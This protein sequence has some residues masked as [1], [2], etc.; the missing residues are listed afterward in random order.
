MLPSITSKSCRV[1]AKPFAPMFN[2]MA[3]VC[4]VR[5]GVKLGPMQRKAE[6]V[7]D[8]AKRD[9][10]RPLSY[11]AKQAQTAFNAYVRHRDRHLPCV[12]CGTTDAVQWQAGHYLSVGAR[13]ELRFVETQVWRQCSQCN[14]YLSGNLIP[15]RAELIRRIGLAEV[16]RLEG[17]HEPRRYRADDYRAIR[18]DYR[19]RLK[20]SIHRLKGKP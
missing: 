5:C 19:A 1:C 18:D 9:K 12:S 8:K 13:P 7:A 2:T 3:T 6:K 16:E 11:W 15:Y 4:S 14:E 10:L 17:P 20:S